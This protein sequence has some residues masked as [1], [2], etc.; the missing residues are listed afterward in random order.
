MTAGVDD[1]NTLTA[2]AASHGDNAT[3][4][5]ALPGGLVDGDH[6]LLFAAIRNLL[7]LV[8]DIA[9]WTRIAGVGNNTAI[10][11]WDSETAPTAAPTVTFS[12]GAAGDSTSAVVVNA[13]GV[14]GGE[15]VRG[16]SNTSQQ[17]VPTPVLDLYTP[18]TDRQVVVMCAW[19]QDDWTGA[20]PPAGWTELVDSSTVLGNDQA[21]YV[22]YRIVPTRQM[23]SEGTIV[24]TGGAAAISATL[25]VTLP[26]TQT[27]TVVRSY[28]TVVKAH[29][30]GALVEVVD[31]IEMAL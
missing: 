24:V 4:T 16:V 23:V 20:V 9:G 27:L 7:A 18:L 25:T 10:F 11:R 13:T 30:A 2:G 26:G 22:M 12:G 5:P 19:K 14:S 1:T 17:D 3:L 21:I 29:P 6:P 15:F 31:A 28:N 8:N